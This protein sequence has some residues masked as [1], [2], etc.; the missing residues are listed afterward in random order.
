MR[1]IFFQ[2][3]F[4]SISVSAVLVKCNLHFTEKF[5]EQNLVKKIA[6]QIK[7]GRDSTTEHLL[8][9]ILAILEERDSTVVD[10]CIDLAVELK[11]ILQDHL[12]H[13]DLADDSFTEE[14]QYCEEL[15]EFLETCPNVESVG[16]VVDR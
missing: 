9:I 7:A 2:T 15:L 4:K 13:P 10:Q 12:K 5:I 3:F 8:S 6:A 14:K 16:E 11:K 1:V